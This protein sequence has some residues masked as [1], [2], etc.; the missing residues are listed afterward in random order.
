MAET[1]QPQLEFA[2]ACPD[3]G[4]REVELPRLLPAI[5]DDFDWRVRD[6]D[7]FRLF[8]LEELVAR[9]PERTRWTPADMEVVLVEA[10]SALLDQLADMLDRV[11][12]EAYL[13]SARRPESVRRLLRL[14]GYDAA[15]L[16]GFDDDTPGT[17][18]ARS[19]AQKLEDL[20]THDPLAMER[21]RT[22]GPRAIHTQKRMVTVED[23][24][25]RL[26]E[27]PLVLRAHAWA[28]WSGAWTTLR[29]AVI[30]WGNSHLNESLP[31]TPAELL[32]KAAELDRDVNDVRDEVTA[33]KAAIE[34]FHAQRGLRAPDWSH[35]PT[36]RAVLHIYIEGYRMAA[37]EV[38]LEDAVP[39]GIQMALS[40][41]VDA[42][43][44][45]SEIR[46]AVEQALGSAPGG[47]FEPGRLR[48]GED[49]HAGDILQGLTALEGV[50][51][52]CLNRFK[53]IG[54]DYADQADAGRIVL[55]GLEVAV[56]DN[57]ARY[58]ERG[59]YSLALHGGR[60]G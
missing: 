34:S 11:T 20:W 46:R 6:Y 56:C 32:A 37:Q 35:R 3:C 21:A 13:E 9:F 54:R 16:A 58:P 17:P 8:M 10:L 19:A 23:Y 12:A 42:D 53:R 48:F 50:D 15:Q 31:E 24:A 18:N 40:I 2:G 49:L 60:R 59:Y 41:R 7:G 26:D 52:V 25:L 51:T 43:Y 38:W 4:V 45:Q 1:P 22:A 29:V 14:I 39:V 36:L 55:E 47:F 44:F 28:T 30:A 5:G 57:D 27:H 33:L